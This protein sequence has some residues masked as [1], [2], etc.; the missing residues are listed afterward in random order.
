MFWGTLVSVLLSAHVERSNVSRMQDFS[1][2]YN[3]NA[4]GRFSS[5]QGLCAVIPGYLS[6]RG[7]E[8][9]GPKL[10]EPDG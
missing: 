8:L 2:V 1:S 7:T 9:P 4:Q 6:V 3:Y 5:V 10:W